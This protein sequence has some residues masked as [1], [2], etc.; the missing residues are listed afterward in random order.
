MGGTY[1]VLE[2]EDQRLPELLRKNLNRLFAIRL[3]LLLVQCSFKEG[4]CL[5]R[6]RCAYRSN[7]MCSHIKGS[8]TLH[9]K[10]DT[11]LKKPNGSEI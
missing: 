7:G 11:F 4:L 1:V 5:G 2:S 10:F 8:W 6:N 3:A 9:V